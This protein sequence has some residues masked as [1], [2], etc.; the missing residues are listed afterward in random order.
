MIQK[1]KLRL[2]PGDQR[3]GGLIYLPGRLY[4]SQ[5]STATFSG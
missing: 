1:P 5:Q 2:G 4:N 3:G